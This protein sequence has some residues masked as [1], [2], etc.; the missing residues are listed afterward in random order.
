M[1]IFEASQ[2]A[3][4]RGNQDEQSASIGE[5]ERLFGWFG[6]FDLCI[7][8]HPTLRYPTGL[9]DTPNN[10]PRSGD[11][12]WESMASYDNRKMHKSPEIQGFA[13]IYGVT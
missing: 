8:K 9:A 3:A 13:F 2:L 12:V 5:L 11:Y 7:S 10:T 1:T 4:G 6:P